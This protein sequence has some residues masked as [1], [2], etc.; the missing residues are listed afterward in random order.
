S[1]RRNLLRQSRLIWRLLRSD[2]EKEPGC[3]VRLAACRKAKI[4]RGGRRHGQGTFRAA[5]AALEGRGS[6][7]AA[8]ARGQGQGPQ[9]NRQGHWPERGIDQGLR[10]EEQDRHR[11]EAL[12][13]FT[14]SRPISSN[15]SR[16][17]AQF[18]S[19]FTCRNRC[20]GTP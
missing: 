8:D 13:H 6:R 11:Q 7:P 2:A 10:Q 18:S 20:T 5:Q 15:I 9:G 14:Q 4:S 12:V 19:T 16:L 3:P 17:S 1:Q